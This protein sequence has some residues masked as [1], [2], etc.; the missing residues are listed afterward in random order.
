MKRKQLHLPTRRSRS[1]ALRDKLKLLLEEILLWMDM[2]MFGDLF[3]SLHVAAVIMHGVI[4]VIVFYRFPRRILIGENVPGVFI[5]KQIM[6]N[7]IND[8]D[9]P[10]EL[11]NQNAF[12]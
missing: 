8:Q 6:L 10:T 2:N 4:V 7:A 12:E 11:E 5:D 9:N 1:N 3:P